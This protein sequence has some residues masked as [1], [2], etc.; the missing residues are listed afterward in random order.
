MRIGQA[1]HGI[2]LSHMDTSVK[3]HDDFFQHANGAWLKNTTLPSDRNIWRPFEE[4]NERNMA[5]MKAILEAVSS[6]T[7]W[8]SGSIEQKVGDFYA[9][10]MHEAEIERLGSQPLD[11]F[12]A[13]VEAIR[14]VRDLCLEIGRLHA[15]G[16]PAGFTFAVSEDD[17]DSTRYIFQLWQGGLGLPDRDYYTNEDGPSRK[18]LAEYEEHVA[19]MFE[20]LGDSSDV[21]R[22]NA[23]L[24]LA[25]ETRLAAASLTQL[26][27]RDPEAIYHKMGRDDLAKLTPGVEWD[28]YLLALGVPGSERDVL[29]RQPR[30]FQE[31]AAM[32]AELPVSRWKIYLRW[33]LVNHYAKSLS[34]DYVNASFDFHG[35]TLSGI[36]ELSPRWKRIKNAV[37]TALGEAVGQLFVKHAFAPEAKQKALE[38]VANVRSALREHIRNLGWMTEATKLKALDKLDAIKFKIGYPLTWRD[39]SSLE[40]TRGSYLGNVVA[41]NLFESRR[42]L[43][44]LGT[45]VDRDEWRARPQEVNAYYYANLNDITFPAGILQ[46][47]FF[48]PEADDAVNYGGIGMIIGHELTHGF[49]DFGC[50]YDAQGTLRNWWTQEDEEAYKAR[51]DLMVKQFDAME[52]L[53]GLRLNGRLTLGENIADL[54]GLKIAFSAFVMSRAGKSPPPIDG[55]SPEQRFFLSYAQSWRCLVTDEEARNRVITDDHAPSKARV[56][57]PLSNMPEFHEA[58]GCPEGSPMRRPAEL[59]PSIW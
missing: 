6:R 25:M 34:T 33:A 9:S 47:P 58:F 41:A 43:A 26:E 13:R 42:A 21:A 8:P 31:L 30:F 55:F 3:P 15:E 54:G 28:A 23:G 4:I 56:N 48:D 40:I 16:V 5:L 17:K 2:Q 11:P 10:G 24:V 44:K 49:D 46:P 37:D 12:F 18:L 39:Y 51:Q 45:T 52:A 27:H 14:S 7:D 35:R 20:L 38:L 50:R 22:A 32:F 57:G 53:P 19:R 59:W 36:R 29:V 1:G